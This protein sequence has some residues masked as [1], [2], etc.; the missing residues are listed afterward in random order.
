MPPGAQPHRLRADGREREIRPVSGDAM[1]VAVAIDSARAEERIARLPGEVRSGVR[2]T[3]QAELLELLATVQAKL[4]GGVLNSR[5]GNLRSSI[6]AELLEDD[7]SIATR[8]FSDGSVPYARTQEFGGR[9]E[10]P[11]MAPVNAKAL[12]FAYGGRMVFAKRAAAHTV[13]IPERSY[14]CSSLDEFAEGFVDGIRK[15]AVEAVR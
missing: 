15:V 1:N 10:I 3:M 9:V 14:L 4:S 7:S 6:Q 5:S 2:K 8:V 13:T 12:A 11:E